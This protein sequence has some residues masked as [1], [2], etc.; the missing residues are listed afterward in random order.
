MRLCIGPDDLHVDRVHGCLALP[1]L[2]S[3]PCA[4]SKLHLTPEEASRLSTAAPASTGRGSP[5]RRRSAVTWRGQ[6]HGNTRPQNSWR[7]AAEGP[8]NESRRSQPTR[9]VVC[10]ASG[11][12]VALMASRCAAIPP[13]KSL[14]PISPPAGEEARRED[15]ARPRATP[16][17][18]GRSVS[19]RRRW[20]PRRRERGSGG[21]HVRAQLSFRRSAAA[22]GDTRAPPAG[23]P[24][25]RRAAG[26][27]GPTR[28]CPPTSPP[29]APRTRQ[30][31]VASARRRL[32]SAAVSLQ[33]RSC[34]APGLP[35]P[36]PRA[37]A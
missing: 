15:I 1:P 6:P 35:A 13:W 37:A 2:G 5:P 17:V 26:G 11:A 25:P 27:L 9:A 4:A 18:F 23:R 7:G 20:A 14:L 33:P 19:G 32:I 28:S 24:A 12:P 22:A 36:R 16:N 8:K 10:V 21:H 34:P 3:L 30:Q 29:R 31:K